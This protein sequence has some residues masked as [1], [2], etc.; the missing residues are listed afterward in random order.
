MLYLEIPGIIP[1][2]LYY[3]F[4]LAS[5]DGFEVLKIEKGA[6][7]IRQLIF[8][9]SWQPTSVGLRS[10]VRL[11]FFRISFLHAVKRKFQ[12]DSPT[13]FIVDAYSD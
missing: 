6:L 5:I 13:R 2:F 1:S 10:E 12:F 9:S 11:D 4:F 8:L 3:W 7:T